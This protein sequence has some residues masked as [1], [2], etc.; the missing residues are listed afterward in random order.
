MGAAVDATL[1]KADT[2]LV[3]TPAQPAGDAGHEEARAHLPR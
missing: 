3:Y 1:G 2:M